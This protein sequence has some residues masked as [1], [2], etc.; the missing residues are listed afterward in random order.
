MARYDSVILG[1]HAVLLGRGVARC[2]LGLKGGRIAAIADELASSDGEE[3]IDARGLIIFPGAVDSHFHIGIYRPIAEDARSET[4]SSL[5]GGVTT[6]LSYFRTGGHYL[7]RTGPYRE[8]LPEVLKATQGNAYTDYGYHIA[9]M[10]ADQVSEIDWMASEAGV[11]TFKFFMFYKG[12]NLSAS[13]TDTKSLTGS[14]SYDLGH[15]YAIM[16]E[17]A[18]ADARYGSRGRI[19]VSVHCENDEIIKQFIR[20]VNEAGIRGLRAYSEARPTVSE[21]IAVHD[22]A[23]I[24]ATTKARLNLLHLSSAEALRAALEV[25]TLYPWLDVRREATLHHLGLTYDL[26]EGKGLG[27]KVNPPLRTK[28]DVDALWQGVIDG[29]I[30]WVGSDHACTM[31]DLKGDELWPAAAGFGGT[32]LMYPLMISEGYHKRGLGLGRIAELLSTNPARAFAC[33]PRKGAIA[34]GADADLAFVDLEQ[35]KAVSPDLLHSAQDH[36]PFE[37]VRIK[38][39]PVRTLLRGRTTFLDGEVIGE[40]RGEFIARPL[41]EVAE[42]LLS[43]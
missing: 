9:P 30:D 4:A 20:R 40:P 2:D 42:A 15:L 22:S 12:L 33:D 11:A 21:R 35:E 5:V 13:S 14:E 43:D 16:D 17:V 3:V 34:L 19:S 18:K 41:P 1:G 31:S 10:T 38:G 36:T 23:A 25:E 24:A 26:L 7:N 27:G 28:D 32:S 29:K 6:V 37:G 39:W 8:I